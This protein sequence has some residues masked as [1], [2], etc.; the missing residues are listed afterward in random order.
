MILESLDI[1]LRV[2]SFIP[3]KQHHAQAKMRRSYQ[4][5]K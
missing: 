2:S 4:Q 1:L 5:Q 3:T